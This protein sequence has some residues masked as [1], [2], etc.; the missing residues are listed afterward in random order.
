MM[1]FALA[2]GQLSAQSEAT[3][4]RWFRNGQWRQ[5]LRVQPSSTIDVRSF[6]IQYHR[7]P[8][9]WSKVLAFLNRADLA[10]LDTGTYRLTAGDSAYA[11]IS[12]YATKPFS[13]TRF[14]AHKA[15]IDVQYVIQGKEQIGMAYVATAQLTDPYQAD[16]DIAHYTATGQYVVATPQEFFIFFPHVAHRPGIAVDD[17]PEPVKKLVIKVRVQ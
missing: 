3:V 12:S 4:Q 7:Q 10:Q 6:Y 16:K 11:I 1:V 13:E 5:G 14:E 2:A 9:L 17:R 15:Y 8:A